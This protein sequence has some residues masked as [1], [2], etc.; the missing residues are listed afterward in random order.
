MIWTYLRSCYT[1]TMRVFIGGV[2]TDVP[3]R[4]YFTA[5]GALMFP[6]PHGAEASPWLKQDEVNEEWGEITPYPADPASFVY[7]GLDRGK[8]S[9]YAG[10]CYVG[11]R[12][13]FNDGQLPADILSRVP[14]P[15]PKCCKPPPLVPIG[16]PVL[17]GSAIVQPPN[18]NCSDCPNGTKWNWLVGGAGGT[19]GFIILNRQTNMH[20]V[21]LCVWFAALGLIRFELQGPTAIIPDWTFSFSNGASQAQYVVSPPG[22]FDCLL[23]GVFSLTFHAGPGTPPATVTVS[24]L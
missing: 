22:S 8:N 12:Q 17:G 13:W 6:S 2:E 19:G 3:A 21:L 1:F 7:R 24:P 5:P 23:G 9:G 10:Q 14:L 20:W 16:G 15:F 11:D 4:W 18:P